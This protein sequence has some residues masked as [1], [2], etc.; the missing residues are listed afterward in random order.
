MKLKQ[1]FAMLIMILLTASIILENKLPMVK[2]FDEVLTLGFLVVTFG[3]LLIRKTKILKEDRLIFICWLALVVIGL[4]SNITSKVDRRVFDIAL[5][6]L[7]FSKL[8]VFVVCTKCL[9]QYKTVDKIFNSSVKACKVLTIVMCILAIAN[10]FFDFGMR[11]QK[12]FGIYGFNFVFEYAHEFTVFI[13][14]VY[15]ILYLKLK[16][17]KQRIA[18]SLLTFVT[19]AITLKGPSMLLPFIFLGVRAMV[20][21]KDKLKVLLV[22]A[23][24]LSICVW[25]SRYQIVTYLTNENAP[26]YILYKY[27]LITC[28][29]FFPFGSGFGTYGSAVAA[30]S[31]SP[32]YVTYGFTSLNGMNPKDY[33][34]LNDNYYPMILGQFGLFG[35][36]FMGGILIFFYKKCFK[37]KDKSCKIIAITIF[38]YFIIHS[39][40]S[41][42]LTS[43]A[44]VLGMIFLAF[45]WIYDKGRAQNEI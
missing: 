31:Y 5:D 23:I 21:Y 37:C 8:F 11:G 28:K 9:F 20:K 32:L 3:S 18:Y 43:S 17:Q 15:T 29:K 6:I 2:Y 34:F 4:I 44:G 26:R 35:T 42:I 1:A 40:G 13:L 10:V 33:Q 25:I 39:V 30:S 16:N 41:A 38:T 36:I 24:I 45:I 22:L 19:L 7:S 27:G 12:R 14:C